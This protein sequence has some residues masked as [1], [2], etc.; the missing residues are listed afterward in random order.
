MLDLCK[1][2]TLL[3][4][5]TACSELWAT[6][7]ILPTASNCSFWLFCYRHTL[8]IGFVI[9]F[10]FFVWLILVIEIHSIF[11]HRVIGI[12]KFSTWNITGVK[13][14]KDIIWFEKKMLLVYFSSKAS[15]FFWRNWIS[16]STSNISTQRSYSCASDNSQSELCLLCLHYT[17]SSFLQLG[18]LYSH[19]HTGLSL[20]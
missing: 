16:S 4:F 14:N 2:F 8:S 13:K 10:L 1:G 5:Y 6:K 7:G 20:R 15:V 9:L 11:L 3:I 17:S 19:N 18:V 12:V